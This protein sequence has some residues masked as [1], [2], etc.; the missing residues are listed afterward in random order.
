MGTRLG[1]NA[2]SPEFMFKGTVAAR[3]GGNRTRLV[4]CAKR[5]RGLT[6]TVGA[7][8]RVRCGHAE[9]IGM[10]AMSPKRFSAAGLPRGGC[11]RQDV[12]NTAAADPQERIAR[13]PLERMAGGSNPQLMPLVNSR[14]HSL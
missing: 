6:P 5:S 2:A 12:V 1:A 9:P 7:N 14:S 13:S 10:T 4:V 8:P 11:D 3:V